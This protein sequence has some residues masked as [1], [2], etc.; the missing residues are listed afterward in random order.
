M[1]GRGDGTVVGDGDAPQEVLGR[2]FRNLLHDIEVAPA[3]EHAHIRKLQ[4]GAA[5]A[6]ALVFL[7]QLGVGKFP[8]RILVERLGVGVAGRGIEI[9]ITLLHIL[10]V[11]A[12][13]AAETEQPLLENGVAAVP[14]R[15]R[16]T[17]PALAVAPSLQAVLAPA[18][19]AAARLIVREGRPTVAVVGIVLAHRAPLALAE[20]RPPAPPVVGACL[21]FRKAL[22]FAC[23]ARLTAGSVRTGENIP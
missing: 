20:K 6:E 18:V 7:P 11:I 14:Q 3:L 10:A 8:L 17:K 21:V 13:V 5:A 1:D 9:V 16:E 23:H 4:F 19:G 15:R 22:M 2:A 12:L